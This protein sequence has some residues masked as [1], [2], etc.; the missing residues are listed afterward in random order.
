MA[1][2]YFLPSGVP[3][4]SRSF[5]YSPSTQHVKPGNFT[6]PAPSWSWD[7]SPSTQ[8]VK[9]A[10]VVNLAVVLGAPG[11]LALL[12]TTGAMQ[13]INVGRA[14]ETSIAR[15]PPSFVSVGRA[16][17]SDVARSISHI[18]FFVLGRA[19]EINVANLVEA[20]KPGLGLVTRYVTVEVNEIGDA[21]RKNFSRD[22]IEYGSYKD[23]IMFTSK[24][25]T[26]EI[27]YQTHRDSIFYV[28]SL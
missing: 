14:T 19:E 25:A 28:S 23:S 15:S 2:L 26:D 8:H 18:K 13:I 3:P 24:S 22:I 11:G 10:P 1:D 17:E 21:R 20:T 5:D 16:E 12:V 27:Y 7:Y 9:A 4:P 6:V